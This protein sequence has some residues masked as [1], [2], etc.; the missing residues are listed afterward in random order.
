MTVH[1]LDIWSGVIATSFEQ[2][3]EEQKLG[4]SV[5]VNGNLCFFELIFY[6]YGKDDQL[7]KQQS[8]C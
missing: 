8:E 2:V 5:G 4:T 3:H 6:H 1:R 7:Y